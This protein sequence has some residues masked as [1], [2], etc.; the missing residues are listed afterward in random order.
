VSAAPA[1]GSGGALSAFEPVVNTEGKKSSEIR[2]DLDA[3]AS[4][5]P[6]KPQNS[7]GGGGGGATGSVE[8]QG[9]TSGGG[10]AEGS[11]SVGSD[12]PPLGTPGGAGGNVNPDSGA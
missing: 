9:V 1:V 4:K 6:F 8:V 3:F 5:D 10:A 2:K 12:A 11:A 7:G